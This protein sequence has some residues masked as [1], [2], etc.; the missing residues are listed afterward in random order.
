MTRVRSAKQT[1]LV[2][3]TIFILALG[4]RFLSWQDNRREVGKVETFVTMEYTG[5]V[6]QLL[7]GD[8]R[9]FL[10][11][12]ERVHPPGCSIGV[13]GIV[14][15]VG[16]CDTAI[17]FFQRFVDWLAAVFVLLIAA[18]LFSSSI[19]AAAG[20]LAAVSPQFA[21]YS[22]LLLP[23]SLS[24]FPILVAIYFLIRAVKRPRLWAFVVAGVFVGISCWIRANALLLA[25][26]MACC[27]PLLL[28][29]C[30]RLRHALA[31]VFGAAI[32]IVPITIKNAV[33]FH[34]FIPLSPGAG[35]KLLEGIAEY[36]QGRFDIPTTDLGIMRQE[37][38]TYN[39]PDYALLLF[40]PD[41]I[42]RDRWRIKRGVGVIAA[43]PVWYTGV[44]ARR[45]IS[46]FR[47][48]RVPITAVAP[49]VSRN[50]DPARDRAPV[51][52]NS[53]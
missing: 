42:E 23:D 9:A 40:G 2:C 19:A 35:Q 43:H 8:F 14:K 15:V 49:P 46:F 27:A 45:G 30:Q 39:R 3:L 10:S 20:V 38:A 13:A 22:L 41:G 25:P 50:F 26:F 12:V 21:Y 36:D 29:R 28:K 5:S 33:V 24:V 17:D 31:I 4:V 32:L 18:E 44:M 11:D 1:L 7:R 52:T 47:L 34:R 16:E 48:A 51:W 53:P 6:R 37:A